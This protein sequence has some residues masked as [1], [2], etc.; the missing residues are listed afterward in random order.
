MHSLPCSLEI[1]HE[2]PHGPCVT[3]LQTVILLVVDT[4]LLDDIDTS[5]EK[6]ILWVTG[7]P[8]CL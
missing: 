5:R 7:S 4:F 8:R 1:P 2:I 3:Q 6:V